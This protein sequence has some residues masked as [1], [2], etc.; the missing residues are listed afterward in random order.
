MIFVGL[1]NPGKE[2]SETRHNIGF[3][4]IDKL[5]KNSK[6]I[7]IY[8]KKFFNGWKIEMEGKEVIIIKPKTYMNE[9]GKAVKFA[10][11]FFGEK[12]E[13]LFLIHDD[14]DIEIGKIKII[15][16]KGP[17]GHKGVISVIE[18]I[19]NKNFV[20]IRIGIRGE[21]I[22]TN[23]IEYVLSNFL[24]EEKE[25]VEKVIEKTVSA[26]K[27]ILKSNLEKAMSLYNN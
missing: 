17:G 20:R 4:V 11:D 16:D 26:I 23:Y 3:R 1:G 27:E 6:I 12:I 13:N 21:K 24:P 10:L 19:Q 9:S 15:R 7:E 18:N 14:L 2:Y 8:K 5:K 25:I 22:E